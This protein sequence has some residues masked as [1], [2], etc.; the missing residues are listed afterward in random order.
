MALD[1]ESRLKLLIG[2]KITPESPTS[3]LAPLSYRPRINWLPSQLRNW[4]EGSKN[5]AMLRAK[6]NQNP[7]PEK[8]VYIHQNPDSL[9]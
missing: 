6:Q 9:A 8:I 4:E 3:S 5:R 7:Q 2:G 1:K